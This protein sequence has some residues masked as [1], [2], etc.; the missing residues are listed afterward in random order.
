MISPS[1][2]ANIPK[3]S[4]ECHERFRLGMGEWTDSNEESSTES[5]ASKPSRE[6][7]RESTAPKKRLRLSLQKQVKEKNKEN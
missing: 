7:S 2:L 1:L 6:C 4:K 3:Q 5:E